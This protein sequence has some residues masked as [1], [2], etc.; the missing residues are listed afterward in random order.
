[1]TDPYFILI[2]ICAALVL[3]AVYF[4]WKQAEKNKSQNVKTLFIAHVFNAALAQKAA[5]DL[6]L[7]GAGAHIGLAAALSDVT[8]ST[9]A[10]RAGQ[11]MAAEWNQKPVEVYFSVKENDEPVFYVFESTVLGLAVKD[12][13][14]EFTLAMPEQLRVEQKRHFERAHPD[15]EDI[16]MIAVWPVAPGRRLPRATADLGSPSLCWKAGEAEMPVRVE[17]ISGSGI[18]LRFAQPEGGSLP[19][20]S[21]KGRQ[22]ICLVVYKPE[23]GQ[24]KPIV[25]WCTAEIMNIRKMDG[26]VAM[27]MEFTNWAVQ[28]Q[29][30][31]EIHWAHNSPWRGV[32]PILDLVKRLQ[33]RHN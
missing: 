23:N 12:G 30:D 6:K 24:G 26:A 11:P 7:L 15:M 33:A 5:F 32:K 25:F 17:N 1:M 13:T 9:L 2:P 27:G 16:M 20:E 31:T 8:A 14:Q 4:I 3:L 29:G 21:R 10:M 28:E 19:F 22:I 18:A